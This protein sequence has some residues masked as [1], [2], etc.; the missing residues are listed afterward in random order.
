M[1]DTF[2]HCTICSRARRREG[3]LPLGETASSSV[4]PMASQ[5]LY[6][7]QTSPNF[8]SRDLFQKIGSQKT[9]RE[10]RHN[11]EP[12]REHPEELVKRQECWRVLPA[13]QYRELLTK[14][15]VLQQ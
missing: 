3:R 2:V 7:Q 14:R 8:S 10:Y 13:L 9:S 1:A 4:F 5:D 6:G 12:A 15:Q 11:P